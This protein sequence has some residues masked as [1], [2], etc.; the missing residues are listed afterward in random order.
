MLSGLGNLNMYFGYFGNR[1]CFVQPNCWN[2][3]SKYST[4]ATN[5]Q[6]NYIL[7]CITREMAIQSFNNQIKLNCKFFPPVCK[8]SILFQTF[9]N[10][11]CS[12]NVILIYDVS[13]RT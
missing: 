1:A 12:F 9:G 8:I 2:S 13:G 11:N 3:L 4:V 6:M 10:G 7:P 5:C